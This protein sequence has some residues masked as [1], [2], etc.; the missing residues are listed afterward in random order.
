L[1]DAELI[2]KAKN[3]GF[4]I[5]QIG[6]DYFVRARGSSTLSSFRVIRRI[7]RELWELY[8]EMRNPRRP[9]AAE[10]ADDA[11]TEKP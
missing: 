6:V 9:R 8:P 5:Q 3:F 11:I 4:A 2:V 1:I 10:R 7:V